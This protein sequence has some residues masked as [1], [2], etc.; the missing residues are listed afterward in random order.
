MPIE[1]TNAI[2]MNHARLLFLPAFQSA[3]NFQVASQ[4]NNN[5][6]AGKNAGYCSV[7]EVKLSIFL[8]FK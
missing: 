8:C 5:I 1:F 7:K 6:T 4:K 3:I 2:T